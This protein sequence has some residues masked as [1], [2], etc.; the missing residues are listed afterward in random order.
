MIFLSKGRCD[1][2]GSDTYTQIRIP[3]V[4][5][6]SAL[7]IC[8]CC[9][10]SSSSSNNIQDQCLIITDI[11]GVREKG[12]VAGNTILNPNTIITGI[13]IIIVLMYGAILRSRADSLRFT[14]V[15][16]FQCVM[17][18]ITPMGRP[19]FRAD[20]TALTAVTTTT[21]VTHLTVSSHKIASVVPVN[22]Q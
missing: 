22:C 5:L 18:D 4:T 3:S 14:L 9:C 11:Y 13:I 20:L 10:S 19:V 16:L 2:Q 15:G 6:W 1:E 17:M 8:C 7:V 12:G 21:G